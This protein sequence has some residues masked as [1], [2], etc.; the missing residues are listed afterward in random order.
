MCEVNISTGELLRYKRDFYYRGFI[1]LEMDRLYKSSSSDVSR[2]GRGWSDTLDVYLHTVEG[3]LTFHN[4]MGEDIPLAGNPW[5]PEIADPTGALV[6]RLNESGQRVYEDGKG[7]RHHLEALGDGRANRILTTDSSRLNN[8]QYSY[9]SGRLEFIRDTVGRVYSFNYDSA[10]HVIAVAVNAPGAQDRVIRRYEYSYSGDLVAVRDALGRTET[11]EYDDH[12][13]VREINPRGGSIYWAYDETRRCVRTWRDGNVRLRDLTFDTKKN[14]TRLTNSLGFTTIYE[15]DEKR[16]PVI[17]TD[18]LGDRTVRAFDPEGRLL[19]ESGAGAGVES[20]TF[21][22]SSAR[23]VVD[24]QGTSSAICHFFDDKGRRTHVRDGDRNEWTTVYGDDGRVISESE[25]GGLT[26]TYEY[27]RH[28]LVSRVSAPDGSNLYCTRSDDF[29]E[30][31]YWDD[32]GERELYKYDFFGNLISMREGV[33]AGHFFEYDDADRVV[34]IINGDGSRVQCEYDGNDNVMSIT[35]ESGYSKRYEYDLADRALVERMP[36]GGECVMFWDTEGHLTGVRSPRG[37]WTRWYYDAV[38]RLTRMELADG[39]VI[40]TEYDE[41]SRC[42]ALR[43]EGSRYRFEYDGTEV[44]AEIGPDGGRTSFERK[45]GQVTVAANANTTVVRKFDSRMRLTEEKS[46]K[47]VVH[48]AYDGFGRYSRTELSNGRTIEY[49][50]DTRGRI[51]EIRDSRLGTHRFTYNV[52]DAIVLWSIEGGSQVAYTYDQSGR[53]TGAR[54]TGANGQTGPE[55]LWRYDSRDLRVEESMGMSGNGWRTEYAHDLMG[56]ITRIERDGVLRESY[57]YDRNSNIV[58]DAISGRRDIGSGDRLLI[59]GATRLEYDNRG[60]VTAIH[61]P[62][63]R[64]TFAFDANS[65]LSSMALP[66]GSAASYT[67]DALGRRT[68]KR[69]GESE[70]SYGWL[71]DGLLAVKGHEDEDFLFFPGCYAPVAWRRGDCVRYFITDPMAAP[72]EMFD[73]AGQSVWRRN[74]TLWGAATEPESEWC[75]LSYAGQYRDS[76]SGLHYNYHRY[77]DP[78]LGRYLSPDPL[79]IEGGLNLYIGFDN[80]LTQ[81]DVFGLWV[82]VFKRRCHWNADQMKDFDRKIAFYARTVAEHKHNGGAPLNSPPCPSSTSASQAYK[83]CGKAAPPQKKPAGAGKA[84][85]CTNDIDHMR[86]KQCGGTNNCANLWPLNSSVNRSLGAQLHNLLKNPPPPGDPFITAVK[87]V[88]PKCPPTTP[89]T[90]NC[91]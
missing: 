51:T 39:R 54:L 69:V 27:D 29:Q 42:V 67:Y 48:L 87:V 22:D 84:V 60:C 37:D 18:P 50:Q 20:V 82:A 76:E 7:W 32:I 73:Q 17:E 28:G 1:P 16:N 85:D 8:I 66:D 13:L 58:E 80:P 59:A 24:T 70:L 52:N 45:N 2:M 79:E 41:F 64:R 46:G 55:Y 35:D 36:D 75:P 43:I 68:S 89:R 65:R 4:E 15:F 90:P 88:P 63:G 5:D 77:Y 11:Y 14:R 53:R 40:E 26:W 6:L 34:A 23:C 61:G 74:N 21:Y 38:E 49:Q 9:Q 78:S 81:I 30:E 19:A 86:D 3:K 10:G 83:N 71:G 12:L 33:E 47:W 91:V 25:P 72:V 56:R 57:A 31:R 62:G 44:I